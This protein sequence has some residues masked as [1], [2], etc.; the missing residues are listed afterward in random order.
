MNLMIMIVDNN[1][2]FHGVSMLV[3]VFQ[4][5][6]LKIPLKKDKKTKRSTSLRYMHES[7]D[8]KHDN[9]LKQCTVKTAHKVNSIKQSPVLEGNIL[10]VH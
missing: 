4:F 9:L 1:I 2:L 3:H 5:V 6:S 10:L 8:L 7:V